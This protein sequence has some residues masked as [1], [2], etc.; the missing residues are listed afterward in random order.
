MKLVSKHEKPVLFF[1]INIQ[2]Y[3]AIQLRTSSHA[4]SVETEAPTK[5]SVAM[6]GFIIVRPVGD[7]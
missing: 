1:P 6:K 7:D 4:V 2:T 5:L 3:T